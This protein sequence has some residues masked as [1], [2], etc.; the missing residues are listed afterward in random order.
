MSYYVNLDRGSGM[1]RIQL[2]NSAELSGAVNYLGPFQSID[3]AL[4]ACFANGVDG[5]IW[6]PP[7]GHRFDAAVT[8]STSAIIHLQA[9]TELIPNHTG[10]VGIITFTG[11]RCGLV[12]E[13]A[14][15]VTTTVDDQSIVKFDSCLRP[16]LN[17][18]S[19][20]FQNTTATSANPMTGFEFTDCVNIACERTSVYP[21]EGTRG[22]YMNG[23]TGG[24]WSKNYWGT[25]TEGSLQNS[26]AESWTPRAGWRALDIYGWEYFVAGQDCVFRGVGS[27]ADP[28]VDADDPSDT[29]VD[30]MIRCES[31]NS[32]TGSLDEEGHSKITGFECEGVHARNTI[33][34]KGMPFMN[35]TDFQIGAGSGCKVFNLSTRT[36]CAIYIDGQGSKP[37]SNVFMSGVSIHNQ[38]WGAKGATSPPQ[39]YLNGM[40]RCTITGCDFELLS[41]GP[42]ILLR[43][44][45]SFYVD[46]HSNTFYATQDTDGADGPTFPISVINVGASRNEAGTFITW[47]NNVAKDFEEGFDSTN[48]AWEDPAALPL[49]FGL[50]DPVGLGF[51]ASREISANMDIMTFT[52][53][54]LSNPR[55]D[56]RGANLFT[57]VSVG[58]LFDLSGPTTKG[59][60]NESNVGLMKVQAVDGTAGDWIDVEI[61]TTYFTDFIADETNVACVLKF[62]PRMNTNRSFTTVSYGTS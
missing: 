31:S 22:W 18:P 42:A 19:L 38:Q 28:S 53:A 2:G 26:P 21:N 24:H 37:S 44:E 9:S 12:G 48:G 47:A 14:I 16:V 59:D 45:A 60:A 36:D 17:G 49:G 27:V 10:A 51:E 5:D 39:V 34:I 57:N 30:K 33:Y 20:E 25:K 23:G 56:S 1:V 29:V 7:G 15:I 58:D 40:D 4:N 62:F 52:T 43:H 41:R 11:D 50:C 55:I 3:R 8:C 46:I 13:G 61:N 54:P 32:G 35:L 6:L